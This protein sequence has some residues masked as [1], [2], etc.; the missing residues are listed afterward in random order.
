MNLSFEFNSS[1]HIRYENGVQVSGPHGGAPRAVKV[2]PN[3]SGGKGFTVTI[4]NTDDQYVVQMAPKQMEI[5]KQINNQI[6][7]RGFGSD[8]FGSPFSDYGLTINYI[9]NKVDNCILHLLDRNVDIKYLSSEEEK[10]E[11]GISSAL[12]LNFEKANIYLQEFIRLPKERKIAIAT[13]TD[14]LN[15]IGVDYYEDDDIIN[16]IKFYNK[17]LDIFSLNDDA[18]KNLIV[19]YKEINDLE[20]MYNAQNLLK[21]VRNLGL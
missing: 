6:I 20:N 19:C 13:K 14:E 12:L 11:V 7:L 16:A 4:Y 21:I 5:I 2:E 8:Q 1:D 18:L 17:A 15:N 10:E 3:I 9:N